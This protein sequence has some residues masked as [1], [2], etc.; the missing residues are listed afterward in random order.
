[1]ELILIIIGSGLTAAITLM[2]IDVVRNDAIEDDD[3]RRD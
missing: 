3:D 1:M 2:L